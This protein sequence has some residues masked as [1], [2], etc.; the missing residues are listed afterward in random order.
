MTKTENFNRIV[1][2]EAGRLFF[3]Q[4]L[5]SVRGEKS[6]FNFKESGGLFLGKKQSNRMMEETWRLSPEEIKFL[7]EAKPSELVEK[8]NPDKNMYD[9]IMMIVGHY[10]HVSSAGGTAASMLPLW[11]SNKYFK[12]MTLFQRMAAST[13]FDSYNNYLKPLFINKNP[14]PL[15]KATIGHGLSGMAL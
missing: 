9:W 12:P 8:G 5:G 14:F 2:A 4:V 15:V 7:K 10:S 6:W 1:S 13:T 11:M 3:N